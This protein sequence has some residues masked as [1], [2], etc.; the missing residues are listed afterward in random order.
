MLGYDLNR[1]VLASSFQVDKKSCHRSGMAGSLSCALPSRCRISY[2]AD[3]L[4]GGRS[5]RRGKAIRPRVS[6]IRREK[7][8][9][10]LTSLQSRGREVLAGL[11]RGV[12]VSLYYQTLYDF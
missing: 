3:I 8:F 11:S 4:D 9:R 2:C 10:T 6:G 5:D 12:R 7:L 1:N